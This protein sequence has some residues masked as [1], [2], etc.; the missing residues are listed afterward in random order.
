MGKTINIEEVRE[1]KKR[2][3]AFC[4]TVVLLCTALAPAVFA[5]GG[6]NA[7]NTARNGVVRVAALYKNCQIVEIDPSTRSGP[8]LGNVPGSVV[9]GSGSGFGIGKRGEETEYFVTNRHV[10]ENRWENWPSVWRADT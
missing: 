2:W 5:T 3:I 8:V 9:L 1:M 6:S 4:L 7:A 10:V